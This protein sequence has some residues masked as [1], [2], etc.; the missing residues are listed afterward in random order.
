M[1]NNTLREYIFV[2]VEANTTMT[3][4]NAE[5]EKRSVSLLWNQSSLA[6]SLCY[7]GGIVPWWALLGL[8]ADRLLVR[9]CSHVTGRPDCGRVV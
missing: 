5:K 1:K 3:Q 8:F 6:C 2:I 7:L 4:M 9:N